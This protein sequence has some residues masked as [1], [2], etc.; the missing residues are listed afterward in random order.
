[1]SPIRKP[2][3]L[4]I[5]FTLLAALLA[6]TPVFAARAPAP[7]IQL[8][9]RP[10]IPPGS[11]P[12]VEN[13]SVFLPLIGSTLVPPNP[14]FM[15]DPP[16]PQEAFIEILTEPQGNLNSRLL[17]AFDREEA[18]PELFSFQLDGDLVLMRDDGARPDEQAGDLLFTGL[19]NLNLEDLEATNRHLAEWQ[20]K[21]DVVPVFEDRHLVGREP[22]RP[23]LL[24]GFKAGERIS[25]F[26]K[27]PI[28]IAAAVDPARTLAITDLSVVE[29]PAR[30]F[31]PCSGA[32]TPLGAWTFGRLM[33]DMANQPVTGI[34]PA[35]LTLQWLNTWKVNQVINGEVVPARPDIQSLIID[36]W[37]AKSGGGKLDLKIAPF[38]LLAI[39]NR[40]DLRQN[41]LYGGGSG[42]EGRFVFGALNPQNCAP[43]QF[44]VIFEYGVPK[45]GCFAVRDWGKQWLDLQS[46]PLGSPA[47]L[48]AL[49]AI[50][51]QFA[52]AN[53][54]PT[55]PPN[56]SALNQLRTNEIELVHFLQPW[57]LREFQL[58]GPGLG[59]GFLQPVTVKQTPAIAFDQT[60]TLG[61]YINLNEPAI[62][63]EKH[64]VPL[65]FPVPGSPFLGGAAPV[66]SPAFVWRGPA[67]PPGPAIDSKAR[68]FFSLNTCNA[69]HGGETQTA[70]THVVPAPFGTQAPLSQFMTGLPGGLPLTVIDPVD[71][72]LSWKFDDLERRAQDLDKLVNGKCIFELFKVPLLMVH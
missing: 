24:E 55:K 56:N 7:G 34:D 35:D 12:L 47:Y 9:A 38:R 57:E 4:P 64:Q 69:C 33:T 50:T 62:L 25:I 19:I 44:T 21:V 23:L 17:L 40:V 32:G 60:S 39:L 37:L 46:F 65:D 5:L 59:A 16:E 1:M 31:N 70:F 18:P 11:R 3:W 58:A 66:S 2:R 72:S 45:S 48:A 29:D 67:L 30:T 26:P 68:H 54:D 27:F 13:P 41:L 36:P 28:G 6:L 15:N 49:Q 14:E 63:V 20:Q 52:T 10:E 61:D 51:D 22:I 42:G 8:T 43:M 53:A 71:P